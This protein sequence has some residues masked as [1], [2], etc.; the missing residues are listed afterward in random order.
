MLQGENPAFRYGRGH[1]WLSR[2]PHELPG[3]E[4]QR[5]CLARALDER[6]RYLLCDEIT[7]MLD[8]LTQASILMV[9]FDRGFFVIKF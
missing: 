9:V 6:T 5:V 1:A 8:A 3:G 2:Y 7:S 4:L